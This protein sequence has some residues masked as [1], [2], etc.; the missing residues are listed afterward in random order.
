MQKLLL[1]DD[2]KDA[3]LYL[4][5]VLE[6]EGFKVETA[7]SGKDGIKKLERNGFD[8]VTLDILMP[9]IDGWQVLEEIR[10]D[11]AIKPL[12]VIVYTIRDLKS[13]YKKAKEMEAVFLE[14]SSDTAELI[15]KVK[16]ILTEQ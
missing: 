2:E 6:D 15:D 7:I 13:D 1:I 12:P 11:K 16:G 9:G 3:S 14:K 10:K 5:T 4:K 8:L